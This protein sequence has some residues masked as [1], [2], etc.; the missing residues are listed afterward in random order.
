[1]KKLLILA[2]ALLPVMG[3][4][5]SAAV[6]KIMEMAREDNRTMQHLDILCNR[7][8]GRPAGSDACDNASE[9]AMRCFE[10][11]GYDVKLE[12]AGELSVGFNRGG[13]WG[14]MTG[15]ENMQLHFKT[16]IMYGRK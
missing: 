8:G 1:M 11:W 4:A 3:W 15:E 7:F 9:W 10:E 13:W 16:K 2:L 14:R 6:K 12:K 5:Q